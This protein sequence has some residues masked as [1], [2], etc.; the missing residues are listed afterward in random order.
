MLNRNNPPPKQ[1]NGVKNAYV[2]NNSQPKGVIPR[3][4]PM[5][6]Q[7]QKNNHIPHSQS[8]PIDLRHMKVRMNSLFEKT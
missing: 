1:P 8:Q 7:M 6:P 5:P 4:V 3:P 2:V